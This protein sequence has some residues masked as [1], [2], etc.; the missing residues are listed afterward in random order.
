MPSHCIFR[1][2]LIELL[3]LSVAGGA[4]VAIWPPWSDHGEALEPD[5]SSGRTQVRF[6]LAAIIDGWPAHV[7][8]TGCGCLYVL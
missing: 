2:T 8:A 6:V 7:C 5:Q 4:Y 1:W 3:T